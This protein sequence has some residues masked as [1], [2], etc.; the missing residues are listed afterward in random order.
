ME[1]TKLDKSHLFIIIYDV[2]YIP[3]C[4]TNLISILLI[5]KNEMY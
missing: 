2:L 4:M 1:L 5:Y 3:I